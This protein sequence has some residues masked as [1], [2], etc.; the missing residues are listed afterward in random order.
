M[1]SK[2]DDILTVEH[3]F[4]E[5]DCKTQAEAFQEIATSAKKLG[6]LKKILVKNH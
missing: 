6:F 2:Q 4:L 1:V 5:S 3:V